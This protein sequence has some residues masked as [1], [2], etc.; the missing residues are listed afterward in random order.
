MPTGNV[1]ILF[2][3]TAEVLAS[4]D[5]RKVQLLELQNHP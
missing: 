2:E 5:L 4:R 1:V 3:E